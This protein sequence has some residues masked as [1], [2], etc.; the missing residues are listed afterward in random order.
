M[1]DLNVKER[2]TLVKMITVAS[3]GFAD[4]IALEALKKEI[5]FSEKQAK[6]LK[7]VD[8]NIGGGKIET[9]W[10]PDKADKLGAQTISL[11]KARD[12]ALRRMLINLCN[13]AQNIF[14]GFTEHF[15]DLLS[16][17]KE[18]LKQLSS[19]VDK[20]DSKE[21]ITEVNFNMCKK[22]KEKAGTLPKEEEQDK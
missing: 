4:R 14:D 18:E 22:I 5:D 19:I 20:L 13:R 9:T 10:D 21:S 12:K 16:W 17:D 3:T 2:I 8:V 6:D 11:T 1:P 15:F 7:M